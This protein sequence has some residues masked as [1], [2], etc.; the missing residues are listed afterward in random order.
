MQLKIIFFTY[1]DSSCGWMFV[2]S[3]KR[4][5]LL[6]II[7]DLIRLQQQKSIKNIYSRFLYTSSFQKTKDRF[8]V[9]IN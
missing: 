7:L 2:E 3:D 5:N 8:R 6:R 9:T 1:I 4:K